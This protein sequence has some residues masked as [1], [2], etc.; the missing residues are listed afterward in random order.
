MKVLESLFYFWSALYL[1]LGKQGALLGAADTPAAM[2]GC[3]AGKKSRVC[4]VFGI[5][6]CRSVP[7]NQLGGPELR[8]SAGFLLSAFQE[9]T[10]NFQ[11][12]PYYWPKC[13]SSPSWEVFG[14]IAC[15]LG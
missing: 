2:R 10:P 15:L 4:L 1:H 8:C 7:L 12:A 3:S 14:G 5:F 6:Q 11:D 9:K 13:H